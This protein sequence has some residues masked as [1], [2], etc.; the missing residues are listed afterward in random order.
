MAKTIRGRVAP[1]GET[2]I[3]TEGFTGA[4]CQEA[5]KSLEAALGGARISEELTDEYHAA[6]S[7]VRDDVQ[8]R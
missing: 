8:Q 2:T 5:T 4:Q 1:N 6:P 3:V 7:P